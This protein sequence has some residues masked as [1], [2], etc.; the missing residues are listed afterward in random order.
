M[1]K[2][3]YPDESIQVYNVMVEYATKRGWSISTS[4]LKNL[5]EG[6]FLYYMARGWCNAKYWPALAMK[7]VLDYYS[8]LPKDSPRKQKRSGPSL[9]D[10]LLERDS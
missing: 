4:K 9:R 7:W 5:A 1:V 10:R 8:K 2:W 3:E 6:C